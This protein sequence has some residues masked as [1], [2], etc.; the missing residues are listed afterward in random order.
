MRA[1]VPARL[2]FIRTTD[3]TC[4]TEV[5]FPSL[6]LKRAM[7]LNQPVV[8]AIKPSKIGDVAFLCGMKMLKG[9]VVVQ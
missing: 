8:V 1:G 6:D 4:A 9:A 5:V 2:T 3:K 7:P